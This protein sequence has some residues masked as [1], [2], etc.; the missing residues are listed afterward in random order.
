MEEDIKKIQE[1][2]IEPF[3]DFPNPISIELKDTDVELIE[4]LIKGYKELEEENKILKN[5]QTKV[6][7]DSFHEKMAEKFD[8]DFIPK[9]K[10]RE[11]IEELEKEINGDNYWKYTE[12]EYIGMQYQVEILKQLLQEGDDK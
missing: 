8:E 10:V 7:A 2:I 6:I 5:K 3:Y 12:H 4:N 9:S 1:R 11:K